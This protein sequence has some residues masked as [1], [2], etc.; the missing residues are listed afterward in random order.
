MAATKTRKI[1][2]ATMAK[3]NNHRE[4]VQEALKR[5]GKSVYWLHKQLADKMSPNLL[6]SYVRGS[7]GISMENAQAINKVLGLRYTD[8]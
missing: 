2:A 8:E 5:K 6:Y 4:A 1:T 3:W 7:A